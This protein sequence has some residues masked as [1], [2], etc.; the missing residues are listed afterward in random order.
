MTKK[1][2][3]INILDWYYNLII[4]LKQDKKEYF[5]D[6]QYPDEPVENTSAT[7]RSA[8]E[9]HMN[10]SLD[11]SCLMLAT[12]SSKIQKKYE[13]IDAHTIIMRL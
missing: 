8:Y 9:K 10:D 2:N 7:D 13:D 12:M 5:L 3:R 6:T 11:V 1:L 4:I